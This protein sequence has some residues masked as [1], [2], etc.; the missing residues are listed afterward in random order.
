M[1]KNLDDRIEPDDLLMRVRKI[2]NNPNR[3]EQM[4]GALLEVPIWGQG[5]SFDDVMHMLT[6]A[7]LEEAQ[8]LFEAENKRLRDELIDT[9]PLLEL[10]LI[11]KPSP[12]IVDRLTLI[13][14]T[15]GYGE[16][17]FVKEVAEFHKSRG[18][19]K[20]DGDG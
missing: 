12:A 10:L 3:G 13:N 9:K 16:S 18:G 8:K 20:G 4:L 17:S 1:T 7:A 14:A 5:M 19:P 15:L 6:S 2:G 11:T